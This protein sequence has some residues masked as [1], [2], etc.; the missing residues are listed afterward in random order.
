[1]N[2]TEIQDTGTRIGNL[3]QTNRLL[4]IGEIILVFVAAFAFIRILNPLIG[5]SLVLKQ[6]TIWA[7]NILMLILV[8]TGIKLRGEKWKHFGLTFKSISWRESTNVF[9]LSLLVFVLALVGFVFGSIVMANITGIPDNSNMAGYD[10][11]KHNIWML[12]LTLGGVY[13][14]SSF[15]EEVIYRAFLINRISELG[16]GTKK[17]KFVA[18]ILSSIIFG[19]VH[20]EWGPMGIVQTGFMGLAL[21]ICY[22]K[23]K[24]RLW[25]L[26]LAHAYMDTLLMIQMYLANN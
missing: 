12:L 7:A 8:W 17:A 16:S 18:V 26:I 19:L 21:G 15:G 6:A 3:L 4:K 14:V 9:L 13:I 23:F 2:N 5:D 10:Y 20:Y 24:K 25:I 22:I 11:L 1:M